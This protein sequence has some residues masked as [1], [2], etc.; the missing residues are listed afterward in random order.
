MKEET[1]PEIV[2]T[3][4][5]TE[6]YSIHHPLITEDIETNDEELKSSNMPLSQCKKVD[7]DSGS[8]LKIALAKLIQKRYL[9]T[10]RVFIQSSITENES[11]LDDDVRDPTYKV[12][13]KDLNNSDSDTDS[14]E[15]KIPN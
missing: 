13:Q 15:I 7:S 5:D 1:I 11:D 14:Y 10:K 3:K 2:A 8:D 12:H 9:R 4:T 6:G